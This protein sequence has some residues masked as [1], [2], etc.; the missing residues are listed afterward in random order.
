MATHVR[1]TI[2]YDGPALAGHEMDVQDLAPALL[3]LAD[4]IQIA[5]KKFNGDGADMRVLVNAD[6]EQRCFQIDLSLVQSVVEKAKG[7]FADDGVKSAVEIARDIGIVAGSALSLFKLIKWLS[8]RGESGTK[9]QVTNEGGMTTLV[10]GKGNNVT[11]NQNVFLLASDPQVLE[12]VKKVVQPLQKPGYDTLS[13]V[14]G[15]EIVDTLTTEDARRANDLP[16]TVL[17]SSHED[18]SNIRGHIRIKSAQYEGAAKWSVMWG[19]RSI[20]VTM[21]PNFV[22]G[23]QNNEIE[24]P[25]NTVLDVEMEQKIALDEHGK[26]VGSPSYTVIAIYG[27]TLPPRPSHQTDWIKGA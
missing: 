9:F 3:A 22:R 6:V 25:P 11:V 12:R 15:E 16:N 2:R 8:G 17:D 23:F 5:N 20:D 27:L 1:T 26:A 14:D 10:D 4:I 24:A 19:G 18:T 21:E 7:F 13:F